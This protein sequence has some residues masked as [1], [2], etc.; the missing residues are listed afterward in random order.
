MKDKIVP[1]F[2]DE[3]KSRHKRPIMINRLVKELF[4]INGKI[5][6]INARDSIL[7]NIQTVLTFVYHKEFKIT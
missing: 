2:E 5:F 1:M 4:H 6:I 3:L 7:A